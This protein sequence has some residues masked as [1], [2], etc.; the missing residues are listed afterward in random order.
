MLYLKLNLSSR[1]R[2][3]AVLEAT[4]IFESENKLISLDNQ[5]CQLVKDRKK[6]PCTTVTSCLKYNGLNLPQTIDIEISWVLDAKKA[7]QPRLFFLNDETRNIRNSSMRLSRGKMEC[8]S[9]KVYIIENIKDKLTPLEVEMRYDLRSQTP[10]GPTVVRRRRDLEPVLD[11]NLGLVQRDSIN[12][13]KNCGPDNECIP[14]IRL[15]VK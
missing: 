7:R 1:S 2:P 3:V 15:E 6:V 4:T 5:S 9:E 12:I 10:P 8:R 14:D 13:Q 11:H